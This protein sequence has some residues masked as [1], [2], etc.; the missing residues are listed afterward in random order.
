MSD[1][2][3]TISIPQ[4]AAIMLCIED[5]IQRLHGSIAKSPNNDD[6]A[7]LIDRRRSLK[8]LHQDLTYKYDNATTDIG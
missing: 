1:N 5:E 7:K 8:R 4:C 2:T 3:I 6:L